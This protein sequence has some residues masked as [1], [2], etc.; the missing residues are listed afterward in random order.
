MAT[1]SAIF[2]PGIT[3]KVVA[4]AGSASSA[5]IV[6][7]KDVKFAIVATTSPINIAFGQPGMAAAD[8]TGFLIPAGVIASFDLGNAYT[9]IRVFNNTAST[10]TDV[11]VLQLAN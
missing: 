10:A 8:A 5:E 6:L 2:A 9:S 1:F 7:G 3:T 4:L 11:Y